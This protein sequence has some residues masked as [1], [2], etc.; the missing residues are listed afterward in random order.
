MFKITFQ[1]KSYR[2]INVLDQINYFLHMSI[3]G[4]RISYLDY[5][6]HS[7]TSFP[8]RSL[9]SCDL[10][11][12]LINIVGSIGQPAHIQY[13][14]LPALHLLNFFTLCKSKLTLYCTVLFQNTAS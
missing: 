6:W 2:H 4:E 3:L 9:A 8:L 12:A 13:L 10:E 5:S 1:Q 11:T 14:M 7:V